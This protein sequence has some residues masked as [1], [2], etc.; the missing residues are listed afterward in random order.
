MLPKIGCE[1]GPLDPW[2]E[3]ITGISTYIPF[4]E[5]FVVRMVC[6]IHS[7]RMDHPQIM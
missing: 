6:R 4:E 7:N 1:A 5:V 2:N 3:E